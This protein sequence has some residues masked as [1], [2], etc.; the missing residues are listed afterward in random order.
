MLNEREIATL[1]W[2]AVIVGA[3]LAVPPMRRSVGP[4]V[5]ATLR[6]LANPKVSGVLL[7]LVAWSGLWV[8]IASLL[9]L[10][11]PSLLK[12]TILVVA[13]VGFPLLLRSIKAKSGI[14]IAKHVRREAISLSV[15]LAFYLN[16]APLPLWGELMLQPVVVILSLL[17]LQGQRSQD[18]RV[19]GCSTVVLGLVAAGLLIWTT[20]QTVANWP[21]LDAR[22]LA[23]QFALSAWLPLA[24]FPFLYAFAFYAGVESLMRRLSFLN[25]DM[26]VGARVGVVLGLRFSVRWAKAL[27]G[28]YNQ[29]AQ[30]RTFAGA[31]RAMRDFRDDVERRE[32]RER[33]RL[34]DLEALAGEPGVDGNGAQLD[35]REFDGTKRALRFLHTAQGMRFERQGNQFWDELTDMVLSPASRYGLPEEHGVVVETTADKKM[36]RAWRRL[37]SGWVLGIGGMDRAGEYLYSSAEPPT[38][39]P[40]DGRKWVDA[41]RQDWP[42]DWARDD[43]SRL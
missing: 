10:W 3:L 14:E 41:A 37:P 25:A 24:M 23:L 16:V 42:P 18:M 33:K 13:G 2:F 17:V 39:W 9:A 40:G 7:L 43:G 30:A 31:L 20:V 19:T 27:T 5:I 26:P 34:E 4:A 15:L 22:A 29:V 1:I 6:A 38:S 28:R 21:D 8:W 11:D 35:R 36:W 12:D 32:G